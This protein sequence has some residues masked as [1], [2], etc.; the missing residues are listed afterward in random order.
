MN[1]LRDRIMLPSVLFFCGLLM[2]SCQNK[3]NHGIIEKAAYVLMYN[4]YQ[5]NNLFEQTGCRTNPDRTTF[6]YEIDISTSGN[7]QCGYAH[8]NV[9]SVYDYNTG[10]LLNANVVNASVKLVCRCF[11]ANQPLTGET[12]WYKR[13]N[14]TEYKATLFF[15]HSYQKDTNGSITGV[16]PFIPTTSGDTFYCLL[17]VCGRPYK[18][19]AYIL[20]IK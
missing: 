2:I 14:A 10:Q 17:S 20:K 5:E 12:Q 19:T 16:D 9:G 4:K 13:N 11:G 3:Y 8:D 7:K 15:T 18:G 1:F 6:D